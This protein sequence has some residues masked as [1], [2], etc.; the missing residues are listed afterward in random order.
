MLSR[1][2]A[3]NNSRYCNRKVVHA[4]ILRED[5]HLPRNPWLG[6]N[7]ESIVEDSWRHAGFEP[8]PHGFRKVSKYSNIPDT[9]TRVR[10]LRIMH[11]RNLI[12]CDNLFSTLHGYQ[13]C[14][15]AIFCD[16]IAS[17]ALQPSELFAMYRKAEKV[18]HLPCKYLPQWE[19]QISGKCTIVLRMYQKHVVVIADHR[20]GPHE[21]RKCKINTL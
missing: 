13:Q 3:A 20:V 18:E 6:T 21:K 14:L 8:I 10:K 9:S 11:L 15:Q 17:G 16:W 7:L 1:S 4:C 19:K 12:Q 2:L 5:A